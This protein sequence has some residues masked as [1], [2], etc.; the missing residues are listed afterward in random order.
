MMIMNNRLELLNILTSVCPG[1][2][3]EKETSLVDD[4][5]LESLDLVT[6]VSEMMDTFDIELN[7][8]DL[9][10]EHFNSVDAM[11]QLIEERK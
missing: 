10:P 5:I 6:I 9:L 4:E 7:V 11:M 8:E 3:F 2:D 1:V